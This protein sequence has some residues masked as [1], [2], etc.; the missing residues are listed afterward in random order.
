MRFQGIALDFARGDPCDNSNPF[1]WSEVKLNLP[2]S[3]L[4][5][6]SLLW[7]C[8]WNSTAKA[9]S[10]NVVSFVD[11]FSIT[12]FSVENCWQCGRQI[13]SRLQCLGTQEAARKR[14]APSQ[15][16]DVWAGTVAHT[17]DV[18]RITVTELK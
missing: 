15:T 10:G 18:V 4:F 2:C 9:I 8:K 5:D 7:L 13:A 17:N 3:D 12:G 1:H 11:D 16:P 6:P 14:T